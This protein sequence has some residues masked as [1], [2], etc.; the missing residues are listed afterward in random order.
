MR[1]AADERA[2]VSAET[3]MTSLRFVRHT[4]MYIANHCLRS[5]LRAGS[6]ANGCT[7]II[8]DRNRSKRPRR[9]NSG[10]VDPNIGRALR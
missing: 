4:I 8:A 3:V 6:G 10:S 2:I 5:W 1:S 9:R 7:S